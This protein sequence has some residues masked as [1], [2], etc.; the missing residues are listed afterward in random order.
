[1]R[2]LLNRQIIA[3]ACYD[4]A[5]SAF[6]T[7][8]MA[9][10]FP[11]FFKQYWSSDIPVTESTFHLS[12]A[13]SL[14]G[15]LIVM[16][17]P[18]LGAIADAGQVRKKLLFVFAAFG[19][20]MTAGL[21]GVAQGQWLWA[22]IC[23]VLATIG[24][25]GSV[26]FYDS[27]ILSVAKEEELDV[28]SAF[29]FAMG[30][31]GGGLLFAFDVAMT[32]WPEVFGLADAAEAVRISFLSVAIW[33]ALFSIP[34]FI[35]VPEKQTSTDKSARTIN[36]VQVVWQGL[37]Q[38]RNTFHEI[39]KLRVVFL[40]LLAY[41][42]YIDGV[43][44]IIRM[45]V[46]YGMSIGLDSEGLIIALLITQFVGFPAAIGFG[47][48]GKYYGAK[49]GILL[50]LGIY[51]LVTLG[52]FFMD[53][54][55]DFYILAVAIGLVQGGVQSLSRSFYAR[56]IPAAKAAEFFGFYNMMGKF[57]AV[58]GPI[59]MGT[60]GLLTGSPRIG[61]LSVGLLFILGGVLLFFVDEE[62]GQRVAR[63]L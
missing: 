46:D 13:N 58:L 8:V 51:M 19:V 2:H 7:V 53:S 32:L 61:I 54:S 36:K 56:I 41:W 62:E 3:W 48:L 14:S 27:L 17:A 1:M 49:R 40:F 42:L 30:Y 63:E 43:D 25:M 22:L 50:A 16:L 35:W 6:A 29:G 55:R 37:Y 45:A 47:F 26:V 24:F 33:W 15:V 11:L 20:L 44:T 52:A 4:W 34:L 57:A 60:V 38:L 28:V 18:V 9:G 12:I 39:R 31:L 10:F 5:N 59:M 23:F 21:Y